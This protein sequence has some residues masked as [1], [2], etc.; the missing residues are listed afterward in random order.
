M[1]PRLRPDLHTIPTYVPR[2]ALPDSIDPIELAG[3]ETTFGPLPSALEAV[4]AAAAGSNRYQDNRSGELVG[5][6]ADV[7]AV[8]RDRVIAGCGSVSLCHNLALITC[9]APT[10]EV[11]MAWRSF[12]TY[13]IAA[14][15]AGARVVQV[16]LADD[17]HDLDAM[18]A[19][20]TANTRLVFVCNPNN[21][22]AT[23]VGRAELERFVDAVPPHVLVCIDE[24]YLEFLRMPDRP[25]GVEIGRN[26]PNVVALRTFSKAYG[27]ASL[28]V[29]YAVG[30]P[31]V[32]AAL[33]RVHV[34]FSVGRVAQAAA[35][36]S[37]AAPG[38]LRRRTDAVAAERE[39]VRDALCA[40]GYPVPPSQ[41]NFLWLGLADEA[42]SFTVAAAEAGIR[43]ADYGEGVRVTIGTPA[44]NDAFLTFAAAWA[45]TAQQCRSA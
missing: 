32:I 27:L 17:V 20:V 16:P 24:A 22:T 45:R 37:L 7:L 33:H 15:I 35:L 29:G 10:D 18:A 31:A 40:L 19:A 1:T 28:R 12:E 13:P 3:N 44:E 14:R 2:L 41:A 30:D 36:A 39:R 25:D 34:A 6:L 21:P 26:R 43:V 9:G 5:A 11:L 8:P 38:E 23:A 42:T 4:S